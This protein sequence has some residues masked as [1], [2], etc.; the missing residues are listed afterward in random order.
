MPYKRIKLKDIKQSHSVEFKKSERKKFKQNF[1][2]EGYK[3]KKGTIIVA[4]NNKIVNGNHRYKLLIEKYGEEHKIIVYKT[5]IPNFFHKIFSILVLIVFYPF[6]IIKF[7]R[8]KLKE[9]K[10]SKCVDFTNEKRK[11]FGVNFLKEGYKPRLGMISVG[12]DN[13]IINGNH[14][15]CLL[16]QK[17]GENHTIIVQKTTSF[18]DLNEF[19][20]R[21]FIILALPFALIYYALKK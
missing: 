13:K 10:Q 17:Y 21:I 8:L 5:N 1:L 4:L 14:R 12:L 3:P 19:I 6:N 7:K 2:S 11:K 20:T 18:Y 15:Y 16:L 9:I